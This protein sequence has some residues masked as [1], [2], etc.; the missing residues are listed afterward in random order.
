MIKEQNT[1]GHR[2]RCVLLLHQCYYRAHVGGRFGRRS[3]LVKVDF[4]FSLVKSEVQVAMLFWRVALCRRL[5]IFCTCHLWK[6]RYRACVYW[7]LSYPLLSI[8]KVIFFKSN[9][10]R[11]IGT[12]ISFIR[13]YGYICPTKI[14]L[15]VF[16]F[17][18]QTT[19]APFW[20]G[21]G[22]VDKIF[23][24]KLL[25]TKRTFDLFCSHFFYIKS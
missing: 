2:F 5:R 9:P 6:C 23:C 7:N 16:V 22:N 19:M 17:R 3:C 15:F 13:A 4:A 18:K 24:P 1:S 20:K 14:K 25:P 10:L 11:F 8:L 21:D 12:L